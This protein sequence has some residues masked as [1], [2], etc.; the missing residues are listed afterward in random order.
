MLHVCVVFSTCFHCKRK[1]IVSLT[2]RLTCYLVRST[3]W[4]SRRHTL[5]LVVGYDIWSEAWQSIS[6]D[7][8]EFTIVRR[9]IHRN[10]KER[11]KV[12]SV[13]PWMV[14]WS[15]PQSKE[16]HTPVQQKK[17]LESKVEK[18]G[19][20]LANSLEFGDSSLRFS[21]RVLLWISSSQSSWKSLK[22]A[23]WLPMGWYQSYKERC[24]APII[25]ELHAFLITS[26]LLSLSAWERARKMNRLRH[27]IYFFELISFL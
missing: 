19:R 6:F 22:L 20:K 27:F 24:E 3:R 14:L 9:S 11:Y 12:W 21:Y 10:S 5:N 4:M 16:L 7:F 26:F 18:E 8:L 2:K 13:I 23:N 17:W 25:V 15:K 1:E